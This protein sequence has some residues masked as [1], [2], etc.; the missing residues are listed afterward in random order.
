M[1][2]RYLIDL[3]LGHL[4]HSSIANP[5]ITGG[6]VVAAQVRWLCLKR[7]VSVAC[8][9]LSLRYLP[10]LYHLSQLYIK[11]TMVVTTC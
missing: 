8:P 6:E 4:Y 10:G 3:L 11:A 9:T 5:E 1:V 7:F 2:S